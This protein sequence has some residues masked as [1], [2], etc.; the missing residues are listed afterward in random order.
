MI[1]VIG[2]MVGLY[3]VTRMAQLLASAAKPYVKVFAA[4]TAVASVIGI[5]ALVESGSI[6]PDM[7]RHSFSSETASST[8]STRSPALSLTPPAATPDAGWILSESKDP[9]DDSRKVVLTVS[10][11]SGKTALANGDGVRADIF[12]AAPDVAGSR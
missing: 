6:L 11:A 12:G 2:V 10:A 5:V 8:S 4:I 3:I 1:P 7:G 9:L